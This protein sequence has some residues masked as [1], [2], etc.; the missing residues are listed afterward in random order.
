MC[1]FTRSHTHTNTYTSTHAFTYPVDQDQWQQND[2][3]E[4]SDVSGLDRIEVNDGLDVGRHKDDVHATGAQL[5]DEQKCVDNVT[6][7]NFDQLSGR[8]GWILLCGF[9]W[10]VG[11]VGGGCLSVVG[12]GCWGV[13]V[14][15]W[16]LE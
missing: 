10:F 8:W 13:V 11:V 6:A 3:H 15:V 14:F 12:W 2:Q 1:V 9:F 16:F 5:V 7:H 4:Q